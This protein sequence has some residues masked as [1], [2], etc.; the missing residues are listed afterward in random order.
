MEYVQIDAPVSVNGP[1]AFFFFCQVFLSDV[2]VSVHASSS[3]SLSFFSFPLSPLSGVG[4]GGEAFYTSLL[5]S[6]PLLHPL[7]CFNPTT[8]VLTAIKNHFKKISTC[9][10]SVTDPSALSHPPS[11]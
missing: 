2:H 10:S 11:L 4:P 6:V 7:S 3:L 9:K 8:N 1:S 5:S